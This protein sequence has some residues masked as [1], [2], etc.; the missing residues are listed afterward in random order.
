MTSAASPPA[1]SARARFRRAGLVVLALAAGVLALAS[2][3]VPCPFAAAL[4]IPCPGCGSTRAV[5]ALAHGDLH[6]VVRYNAFGPLVAALIGVMVVRSAA[7]FIE[8]GTWGRLDEG[9][10]GRL[11]ARA[12][13]VVAVLEVALWVARF[14]GAFGG[15]VP[16]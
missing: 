2:N 16:V 3:L 5:L 15:P 4:R 6:G 1:V 7:S 11:V 12:I 9:G 8:R 10:G 13:F 14:F